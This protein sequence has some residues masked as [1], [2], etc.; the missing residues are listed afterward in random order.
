MPVHRI[1]YIA[2][3][4][5]SQL[6]VDHVA[7][8][9]F[10][11]DFRLFPPNIDGLR[12][13]ATKKKF[14]GPARAIL[15]GALRRQYEGID[16]TGPVAESI[17]RLLQEDALT[18][19]TG[20]QLCL[21]TGPLYVPFK[22][23]N[24]IRLARTLSD[25]LERPVVPVFWMAT[26]DHD[27]AEIDHAWIG[28]RKVEWKGKQ[29]GA[30]GRMSLDGIDQVLAEVD[31]LLGSGPQADA[32]RMELRRCYRPAH[33]LAQ[34]T[35]LF[36]HAL[37]GRYGL[38]ILDG[39]D[40]EMKKLFVPVMREELLNGITQRSVAYADERLKERYPSQAHARPINLFH[41]RPGHRSRIE[42]VGDHYQVLDGGPRFTVDELLLD[43]ELRPQDYSPNVLLRPVYQET[44]LPNIAYIGGGGE[45][46][47]WMQLKW[48]F[49]ALQLPMPVVLLRTSAAFLSAKHEEQRR[50]LGLSP[51]DL[52]RPGHELANR[53]AQRTSGLDTDVVAEQQ[54]LDALFKR[55]RERASGIDATLGPSTDAAAVRS[56]RMLTNL[57]GKMDRALRRREAVHLGRVAAITEGLF[58]DGGL[59]ERRQNVL[60]M[61]AAQGPA[62]L[63]RW[64]EELDPLAGQFTLF[65]EEP[66]A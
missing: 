37:F 39:D 42:A 24:T 23:L 16:I 64:L 26:E 40:R 25:E 7:G 45:V 35:R 61:L 21:F 55:L 62:V 48:L 18:V 65:A 66:A 47:Y 49:Q 56:Q 29:A 12:A 11:D 41:L 17:E 59:Q 4:R 22:L 2:T 1:P 43:L 6:V 51:E 31:P 52:F 53:V 54:E 10:L 14:T 33:T 15:V 38:V 58:P 63:D 9:H 44:V 19:T 3:N 36:V 5:F 8:D 50:A 60:P 46:A 34:A 28:G 32:M 27:R 20:H 30:T 57:H 13:A